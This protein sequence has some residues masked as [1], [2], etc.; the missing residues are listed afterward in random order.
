M[1]VEPGRGVVA[2]RDLAS[3]RWARGFVNEYL[4]RFLRGLIEGTEKLI[5]SSPDGDR[6]WRAIDRIEVVGAELVVT[7]K[8]P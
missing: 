8:K 3:N 6:R 7:T 5:R 1:T 2:G 4:E